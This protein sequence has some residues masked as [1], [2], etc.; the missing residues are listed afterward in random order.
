MATFQEQWDSWDQTQRDNF[1]KM[2]AHNEAQAAASQP[3][4]QPT[5]PT[6]LMQP[7]D[8]LNR[9]MNL[10]G[11]SLTTPHG[12][13]TGPYNTEFVSWT[14][15]HG[16]SH[17][18]GTKADG[19][20]Q[21]VSREQA[22]QMGYVPNDRILPQTYEEWSSGAPEQIETGIDQWNRLAAG[23]DAPMPPPQQGQQATPEQLQELAN[24]SPEQ[25]ANF[26]KMVAYN[27]ANPN[28]PFQA[29]AAPQ[30]EY[31]RPV[32]Q[33]PSAYQ[34]AQRGESGHWE[35]TQHE[36]QDPRY[37]ADYATQRLRDTRGYATDRMGSINEFS[38]W[39]TDMS[40]VARNSPEAFQQWIIEN[41]E[42]AIR[43]HALMAQESWNGSPGEN[44]YLTH[45]E[46][47]QI[48]DAL[49][50]QHS[51]N[52]GYGEDGTKDG[53]RIA[54]DFD[55]FEDLTSEQG[56]GDIWKLGESNSLPGG[57]N[58]WVENNPLKAL[59][60][61][62]TSVLAPYA[63][64]ALA[65]SIG[66]TAASTVVGAGAAGINQGLMGG[67]AKDIIT[68]AL[69]GGTGNYLGQTGVFG[70]APEAGTIPNPDAIDNLVNVGR[71]VADV[72][73]LIN[74]D[75]PDAIST[76][77]E[78][79]PYEEQEQPWIGNTP[80]GSQDGW[81]WEKTD[82]GGWK[83]V[84]DDP[85]DPAGGGGGGTPVGGGGVVGGE[86][87][88]QPGTTVAPNTSNESR[89]TEVWKHQNP[90][91]TWVGGDE[92]GDVWVTDP[93]PE[94]GAPTEDVVLPLPLPPGEWWENGDVANP[95]PFPD[96]TTDPDFGPL[97][98]DTTPVPDQ[99]PT[100]PGDTGNTGGDT[101]G[102]GGDSPGD[103][104]DNGG[105]GGDNGGDGGDFPIS[106]LLMG[107]AT[108]L[109]SFSRTSADLMPFHY[110]RQVLPQLTLLSALMQ[111][112]Q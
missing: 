40:A 83:A 56:P 46:Y 81:H 3:A 36:N 107:G 8:D 74:S 63:A 94:A 84:P 97:P 52:L 110:Q 95:D 4:P 60:I 48:A 43:Y 23:W 13:N 57:V 86:G 72:G 80:V 109:G 76:G 78:A 112:R 99:P 29:P 66:A 39:L 98:P 88:P 49:A 108:A 44:G 91:G 62:A 85:N 93:P 34:P 24:M 17:F 53:K 37:M 87:A 10:R 103:N 18:I 33:D 68:A 55:T 38:Q 19:T 58:D 50:Y 82:D 73:N 12:E 20:K 35:P 47:Q 5:A 15:P 69:L 28:N 31:V 70:L 59:G 105:D 61:I 101:G 21:M 9:G 51:Q 54:S 26:E 102:T 71:G 100:S 41:P 111:G 25:L 45:E 11:T 27:E 14:N 30:Q 104:G 16:G 106:E 67:D 77:G 65:P 22:L 90:D 7:A 6:G 96:T 42:D 89:E 2:V 1:Q 92:T 32:S 75:D 79:P 64:G